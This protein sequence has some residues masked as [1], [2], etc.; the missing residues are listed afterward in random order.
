MLI[1]L[2]LILNIAPPAPSARRPGGPFCPLGKRP[3]GEN[4]PRVR[5]PKAR[6]HATDLIVKVK[7]INIRQYNLNTFITSNNPGHQQRLQYALNTFITKGTLD[8]LHY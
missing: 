1:L 7:P 2:D 5:A 6:V 3:A 4:G 8:G